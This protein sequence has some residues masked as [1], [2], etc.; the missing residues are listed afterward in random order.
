MESGRQVFE[1]KEIEIN[2]IIDEVMEIYAEH[3]EHRITIKNETDGLSVTADYSKIKQVITNLLSNAIKYSPGGGDIRIETCNKAGEVQ[4]MVEDNGMGIPEDAIPNLFNKF[5]RV[6]NSD[7]KRIGGTGLGLAICREIVNAHG[8]RKW[9]ES[10]IYK[11]SRFYFTLPA[12]SLSTV[13][14]YGNNSFD[15]KYILIVEDDRALSQL[16]GESLSYSN[17]K[18]RIVKSGE[19][20]I[21]QIKAAKPFIIILDILL[22]GKI[23][24]WEM[25]NI[26]KQQE[27]LG[28]IYVIISSVTEEPGKESREEHD[29][30]A[31]FTKPYKLD[32]LMK[33][34]NQLDSGE[35]KNINEINVVIE[36]D[37]A[38][39]EQVIKQLDSYGFGINMQS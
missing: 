29:Y 7:H 26:M 12:N 14:L 22:Y 30:Y 15:D 11:G 20:A 16:V 6:D 5:Y 39:K 34:I 32:K 17:I 36:T 9:V 28:N 10:E 24:G 4:I 37:Y 21:E 3:K 8:G 13:Y 18:Y 2:S 23:N 31:Y 1:K 25:L 19:E 35:I 27:L 33:I 38:K